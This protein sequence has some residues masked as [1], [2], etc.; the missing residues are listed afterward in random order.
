MVS[1]LAN[2][3]F[4]VLGGGGTI[5]PMFFAFDCPAGFPTLPLVVLPPVFPVPVLPPLAPTL[6]PREGDADF[7]IVKY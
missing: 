3:F 1:L 4:E 2:Y 7:A 5:R 6:F